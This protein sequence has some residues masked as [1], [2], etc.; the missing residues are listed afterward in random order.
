MMKGPDATLSD[1][2]KLYEET[3]KKE[4]LDSPNLRDL[5]KQHQIRPFSDES[6]GLPFSPFSNKA[7]DQ[8]VVELTDNP[9]AIEADRNGI[10]YLGATPMRKG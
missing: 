9:P 6:F 3:C 5:I 4:S 1:K 7:N 10:K 2:I 8:M